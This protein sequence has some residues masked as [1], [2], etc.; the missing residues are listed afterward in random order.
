MASAAALMG[1][2]GLLGRV[3]GCAGLQAY[4]PGRPAITA[5]SALSLIVLAAGVHLLTPRVLSP[6]RRA[7]GQLCGL[8]VF[9]V[10]ATTLVYE[11]SGIDLR[12]DSMFSREAPFAAEPQS[13]R[14][15]GVAALCLT[16]LGSGLLLF[17]AAWGRFTRPAQV[18]VLTTAVVVLAVL[19]GHAYGAELLFRFSPQSPRGMSLPTAIALALLAA[20]VLLARPERGVVA[21]VTSARLGGSMARWLLA[22]ALAGPALLGFVVLALTRE[23]IPG[24]SLS[25]ALLATASATVGVGLTLLTAA[26]LNRVDEARA[27]VSEELRLWRDFVEQADDAI[28]VCTSEGTVIGWNPAAERLFG[29]R[30]EEIVGRSVLSLV[31]DDRRSEVSM[32]A[33]C[34]AR[35]ERVPA[36]ETVRVARDGTR[37]E[38]LLSLASVRDGD[39]RMVGMA[40]IIRDLRERKAAERRYAELFESASDG[41]F[42]ADPSGVIEEVNVAGCRLLGRCRGEVVGRS[43]REF[44]P[45]EDATR[46]VAAREALLDGEAQIGDWQLVAADGA[47]IPVEASAAIRGGRWQLFVRDLRARKAAETALARLYREEALAKAWLQGVLDGMPEAVLLVDADGNLSHNKAARRFIAAGDGAPGLDLR[48]PDGA[49]V[50]WTELPLMRALDRGEACSGRELVAHDARSGRVP[51]L[52]SASPLAD[53]GGRRVGAVSVLRDIS[54][55]KEME[56]LREEWT[57]IVAHDLR[58]PLNVIAMSAQALARTAAL[59]PDTTAGRALARIRGATGR[60]GR[61]IRDLYDAARLDARR[62][63][64]A[65]APVDLGDL[66]IEVAARTCGDADRQIRVHVPRALPQV[67]ADAGRVEQ[68]MENLLANAL[69]YGEAGAEVVVTVE[70]AAEMVVVSTR[71]RGPGLTP[72]QL[73]RLFTRFYRARPEGRAEGIGLGLYIARGLVEAQGG[74]IW[75]ESG[76]DDVVFRF[77]LPVA[78]AGASEGS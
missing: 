3:S 66:L 42:I 35:G 53:A 50:G 47:R 23:D 8:V 68:V 56:R 29:W 74:K 75:A 34:V 77:S 36:F 69:K 60:L 20:S 1:A 72:E 61:M 32:L 58:Q 9:A 63:T 64:L 73:A 54:V 48:E 2:L 59:E 12:V 11:V 45:P 10:A 78:R 71:N 18:P 28:M 22:P 51:V 43:I 26:S 38:V 4:V 52:V 17:D 25:H 44:I 76:D 19:T 46:L 41:I 70:V 37:I 16:L 5:N 67:L 31:P 55:L 13:Y 57:A 39:G 27:L 21:I 30:R 65:R 6:R 40:A 24:L 14:S 33:E 49:A 7:A 15:S 62:L